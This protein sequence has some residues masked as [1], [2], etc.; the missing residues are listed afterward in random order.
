M[1]HIKAM[2]REVWGKWTQD[3][4]RVKGLGDIFTK[5]KHI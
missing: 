3:G 4:A 2:L 1:V 5:Q